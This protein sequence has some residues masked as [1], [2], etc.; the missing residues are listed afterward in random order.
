MKKENKN[1]D[2]QNNKE[3]KIISTHSLKNFNSILNLEKENENYNKKKLTEEEIIK[4]QKQMIEN[5]LNKVNILE[6][7]NYKY[8]LTM[9]QLEKKYKNKKLIEN[10]NIN[11]NNINSNNNNDNFT[12]T[13]SNFYMK[14][15]II[16]SWNELRQN[17]YDN[18]ISFENKPIIL[19]KLISLLI[20]ICQYLIKEF[21]N[22]LY[23]KTLEIF[24]LSENKT[25]KIVNELEKNINPFI[26]E[27]LNDIFL[28]KHSE[29]FYIKFKNLYYQNY[30]KYNIDNIE[31]FNDI[32]ENE[33][34][35]KE[36]LDNIK[37]ILLLCNF[38]NEPL[39]F[40]IEKDYD[41]LK[42]KF[43]KIENIKQKENY[44]IL[45]D[46]PSNKNFNAVIIL[47][48]PLLKNGF[49]IFKDFK[50]IIQRYDEEIKEEDFININNNNNDI[51]N[52]KLINEENNIDKINDLNNNNN[53][54]NNNNIN[55]SNNNNIKRNNDDISSISIDKLNKQ[56]FE[57]N[58]IYETFK[59]G[60]KLIKN[61][62]IHYK[63]KLNENIHKK[64]RSISN[65]QNV[66]RI[67]ENISN[68]NNNSDCVHSNNN[69]K[70]NNS[71]KNEDNNNINNNNKI[72]N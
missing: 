53:R 29:E 62:K 71:N 19:F 72:N 36:M 31:L 22:E 69:S 15:E 9:L 12:N 42:T 38:N 46:N 32:F 48:P 66:L 40:D 52:N 50:P 63:E 58:K 70:K 56:T 24:N 37:I 33:K 45:Y 61:K 11:N 54:N 4:Q 39:N 13:S 64:N 10:N 43:I 28:Q 41:K 57:V 23:K 14:K 51:N 16:N 65:Q 20:N 21:F 35:F 47:N 6:K 2:N 34:K 60:N 30:I 59:L 55:N 26:K 17:I 3:K 18:Y 67:F 8:Q 49:S 25:N 1:Y 27:H 7:N 44:I 5:L 68:G